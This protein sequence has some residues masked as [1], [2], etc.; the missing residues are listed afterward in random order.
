ME[1]KPKNI[2]DKRM[3]KIRPSVLVVYS[4]VY[5]LLNLYIRTN[6]KDNFQPSC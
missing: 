5:F 2:N 1:K 4:F 3:N 6:R